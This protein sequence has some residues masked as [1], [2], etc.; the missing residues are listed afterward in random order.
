VCATC[1]HYKK[2][3][4]YEYDFIWPVIVVVI[5]LRC[6]CWY[7]IGAITIYA[8]TQMVFSEIPSTCKYNTHQI[9][10]PYQT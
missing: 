8:Y 10:L 3:W 5:G 6:F 4:A 9:V 1:D 7:G 2:R